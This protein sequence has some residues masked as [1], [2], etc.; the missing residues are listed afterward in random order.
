M[1]AV[2]LQLIA[3]IK[4]RLRQEKG[5]V[6]N[7]QRFFSDPV[8]ACQ[9]LDVAEDCEDLDLVSNSLDIRNR[10]GWIKSGNIENPQA[11]VTQK[12][13]QTVESG[14]QTERYR[15]GARS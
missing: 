7:T 2:V 12:S 3:R 5:V 6:L 11:F 1:D 10:L 9:V 13:A 14:T 8:Y 4:I 15:F